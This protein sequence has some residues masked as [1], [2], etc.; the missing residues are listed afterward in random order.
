[1]C[2][3]KSLFQTLQCIKFIKGKVQIINCYYL[4]NVYDICFFCKLLEVNIE[5]Y[6]FV[7]DPKEQNQNSDSPMF[8]II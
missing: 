2:P 4:A 8:C 1:M 3:K 5:M 7:K 6:D